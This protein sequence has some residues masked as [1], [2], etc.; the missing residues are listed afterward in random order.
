M[1][2]E[3]ILVNKTRGAVR[4]VSKGGWIHRALH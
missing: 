2:R 4:R 1:E 3:R